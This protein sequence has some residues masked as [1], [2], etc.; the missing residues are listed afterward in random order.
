MQKQKMVEKDSKVEHEIQNSA[1]APKK[2][3]FKKLKH[4]TANFDPKHMLW[5]GGC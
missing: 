4:A 1:N 5:K 2:F 3:G